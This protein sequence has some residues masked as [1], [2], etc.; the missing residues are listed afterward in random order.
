M[1]PSI[2]IMWQS[3]WGEYA[4]QLIAMGSC[5]RNIFTYA[6]DH[7]RW[8]FREISATEVCVTCVNLSHLD[9]WVSP[10]EFDVFSEFFTGS[11]KLKSVTVY[12]GGTDNALSSD[13]FDLFGKCE[14]LKAIIYQGA[15]PRMDALRNAVEANRN[16]EEVRITLTSRAICPCTAGALTSPSVFSCHRFS[17]VP[18]LKVLQAGPKLN[19]IV[20]RCLKSAMLGDKFNEGLT[21]WPMATVSD[22]LLPFRLRNPFSA[23]VCG[24]HYK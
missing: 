11:L 15:L 14:G 6:P 13:L 19:E 23:Q 3:T 18:T 9:V 20:L 4:E 22:A 12:L 24:Y 7:L 21:T 2:E 16:L 1:C 10:V 8:I 5:A 17:W